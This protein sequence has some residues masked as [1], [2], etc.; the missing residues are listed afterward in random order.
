MRVKDVISSKGN[1]A[2]YTI[3]PEATIRE[4]LETLAEHNIGALIVSTDGTTMAGI[5]S[6]RDVVRKLR[7]VENLREQTVDTIMTSDVLTCSPE[8][9]ITDLL[10]LMTERRVRHMPVLD[11]ERLL[12]VISI[13]DAVKFRM[14]QLKFERDQLN[15][16][17][18]S[19]Q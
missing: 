3:R 7:S 17:V 16:Y 14:D 8:D 2:V 10:S 1:D 18:A 6:E 15:D 13:G 12:A 19:A 4:L 11:E 9:S 5:V